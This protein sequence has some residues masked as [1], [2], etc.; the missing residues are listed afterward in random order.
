MNIAQ[1]C[2]SF[3]AIKGNTGLCKAKVILR[4]QKQDHSFLLAKAYKIS[5]KSDNTYVHVI[6]HLLYITTTSTKSL[7]HNYER[8]FK[9]IQ[10]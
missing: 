1:D 2:E 5:H 4:K 8:L 3:K 7:D 10:G 6:H 9:A